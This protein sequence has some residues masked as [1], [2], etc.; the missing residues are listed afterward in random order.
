MLDDKRKAPCCLMA[1]WGFA[2]GRM[3]D[4]V[5]HDGRVGDDVE[6]LAGEVFCDAFYVGVDD[7]LFAGSTLQIL[8]VRMVVHEEVFCEDCG[9]EGVAEDVEVFFPVGVVVGVVCSDAFAGE[10]LFCCFVEVFGDEV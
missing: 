10:V 9:A 5:G 1:A 4:Q 8:Q 3:P 2:M 7:G 6:E